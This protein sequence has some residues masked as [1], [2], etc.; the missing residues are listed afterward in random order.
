LRAI[1][2]YN[3]VL[4]NAGLIDL[5]RSKRLTADVLVTYLLNPGT[6]LYVG[7]NNRFE[8]LRLDPTVPP[9]LRRTGSPTNGVGRQFFVKMS[10][11]FRF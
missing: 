2:D 1:L 9:S 11:L 3:A 8:N 4:P 6:A 5:E 10:Y 7:Y